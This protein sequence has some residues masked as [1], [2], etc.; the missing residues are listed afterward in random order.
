M[1]PAKLVVPKSIDID[2]PADRPFGVTKLMVW[3]ASTKGS[4]VDSVLLN[5]VT[6]AASAKRNEAPPTNHKMIAKVTTAVIAWSNVNV[7]FVLIMLLYVV[8]VFQLRSNVATDK[9]K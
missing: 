5:V 8:L 3:F 2:S 1:I 4:D 9:T 6:F 7:E